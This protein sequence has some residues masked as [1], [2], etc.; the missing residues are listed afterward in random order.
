MPQMFLIHLMRNI[1]L[2]CIIFLCS[3][4]SVMSPSGGDIDSIPPMLEKTLPGELTNLSPEQ[5][6]TLFFNEYIQEQSLKKAIGIFPN[7]NEKIQYEFKGDR[8]I[9]TLPRNLDSSKT[10]I[11]R[12]NSNFADEHNVKLKKDIVIPFS[13]SSFINDGKI[14]GDIYGSFTKPSIL[15][16]QGK[17]GKEEMLR[18]EP[19]YILSG[20]RSYNFDFLPYDNYSILAVDQYN[21]RLNLNDSIVSFSNLSQISIQKDIIG[22]ANFFF[23]KQLIEDE[24][25]SLE[26]NEVDITTNATLLGKIGGNFIL[27]T[28]VNI[29]NATHSYSSNIDIDGKFSIVN[30]AE[31]NYQLIAFQDSNNNQLLDTGSFNQNL[32]SEQFSVYPDTLSLRS[33]WEIEI[34]DWKIN[35]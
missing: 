29:S 11:M 7:V 19:D 32:F 2:L 30:A 17:I 28:V 16:W 20:D 6:I 1:F 35:E 9:V 31:G 22:K 3:C 10:Y 5:N 21:R 27:P 8:I 12:L 33:N 34:K 26:S 18:N 4:A 13:L 23:N 24:S 14:I 15:L 25:V